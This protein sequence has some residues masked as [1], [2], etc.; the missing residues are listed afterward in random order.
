MTFETLNDNVMLVELSGEEMEKYHITYES[1]N[2]SNEKTQK[3][4]KNLLHKIDTEN[5]I[6]KGEK[7]VVEA[8]PTE[9][10]GCFFIFTFTQIVKRRYKVKKNNESSVFK[11]ESIDNL[12]DFI[13]I[14][15][16]EN[17]SKQ[18]CEIFGFDNTYFLFIPKTNERI[19]AIVC[20]FGEKTEDICRE[21]LTE[22]GKSL[23]KV[24]LQ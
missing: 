19:N 14:A 18:K 23:G 4:L 22:H 13:S 21:W 12:L 6:S 7:V 10:G 17:F 20:E 2:E 5:R 1:L 11:T 8:M 15:N 16:K 9:N 3:V 24:Y